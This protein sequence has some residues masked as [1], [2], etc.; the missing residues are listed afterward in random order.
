LEVHLLFYFGT[1]GN[2]VGSS[3]IY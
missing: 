2:K 3:R 1:G